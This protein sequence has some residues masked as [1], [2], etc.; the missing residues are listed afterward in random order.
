MTSFR[1]PVVGGVLPKLL[2]CMD[3]DPKTGERTG[4]TCE[5]RWKEYNGDSFNCPGG[6]NKASFLYPRKRRSNGDFHFH[7]GIDIGWEENARILSVTSGTVVVAENEYRS[8]WSHYGKLVVV[9]ARELPYYFLYAHCASICVAKGEEVKEGQLIGT[10]G[11]TFYNKKNPTQK[12]RDGPHLHFEVITK[13]SGTAPG[14]ETQLGLDMTRRGG[15]DQPRLDPLY[16]LEELGPWGMAK[17]H[18]PWGGELTRRIANARHEVIES[19]TA[20]GFFPLGANNH[21]HGGVHLPAPLGSELVAP[22]DAT[23]VAARLD[24]DAT[25]SF[26][27][28]AG[29]SNFILLRHELAEDSY[30]LFQGRD[31]TDVEPKPI[32]E[33][34]PKARA[35]GRRHCTNLPADVVAVKHALHEHLDDGG[36]P[37]YDLADLDAPETSKALWAAIAAFQA[38]RVELKS[39]DGVV[40]IPG[41][42]WTALHHGSPPTEPATEPTV[43]PSPARPLDPKRVVYSL[44]MHLQPLPLTDATANDFAWLRQVKLAPNPADPAEDQ[45]L[46]ARDDREDDLAEAKHDLKG[47]VGATSASGTHA[48]NDPG[49]VLFVCKRLVRFGYHPGP[50]A[51]TCDEPLITAIRELQN[52]HH[53]YF[54]K[55]RNGDGRVDTTGDTIGLLHK[56]RDQLLGGTSARSTSLDPIFLHR[57]TLRD[58][59]GVAKVL[60]NLDVKVRSGEPLWRSGQAAGTTPD[61][62]TSIMLEQVHWELFSEHLLVGATWEPPFEDYTEDL[63]ADVPARITTMIDDGVPELAQDGVLEPREIQAF[64]AS[65]RARFLRRTPCR[66]I[67]HWA[68]DADG[69]AARLAEIGFDPTGVAEQLR[70][71]M[72]W[73][74]AAPVLPGSHFVWHYDPVEFMAEYSEHLDA[75]RP[76]SRDPATHSAL[77]VR[78]CFDNGMPMPDAKVLLYQDVDQCSDAIRSAK[79][80]SDGIA[81]FPGVPHGDYA[82]RLE[83]PPSDMVPLA[84]VPSETT[85]ITI[86]TAV[87]GPPLPR[88]SIHVTVRKHS[89]TVAG[90]VEVWLTHATAGPV[91]G[92]VTDHGKLSFADII[93]GEYLIEAGDAE[94]V[95]VTLDKE[96][97]TLTVILPPPKGRLC[98]KV[99]MGGAAVARREV[100]ILG[101]HGVVASKLTDA[102]G[103]A[104]LELRQGHYEARVGA[105][106][107]KVYVKGNDTETYT[108]ELSE[109]QLPD[110]E[111]ALAVSVLHEDGTPA[112]TELVLVSGAD[113]FEADYPNASG[114]AGFAL[115]PGDYTIEVGDRSVRATVYASCTKWVQLEV[116]G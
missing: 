1:N 60:T 107:K 65:G 44:L 8:G 72:W 35:V 9:K 75:L 100:E 90:S 38:E 18:L 112:V 115:P 113:A 62:S 92:D 12:F 11:R 33:P 61:G 13:L 81:R 7:Q 25:G 104:V 78:V 105:A 31:P 94:P 10:V 91:L 95:A 89:F 111:G 49:D 5:N 71:F 86:A 32:S 51:P 59:H 70:P 66:F 93:Y 108:L 79:T 56:T 54:E 109:K 98:V 30:A 47:S 48:T 36:H 55:E 114:V 24:P 69:A 40:D 29:H 4:H 39:P 20:G 80:G 68:L 82:A 76:E 3:I 116:S 52:A 77:L 64:Y 22:F 83:D 23:I 73:D 84:S 15:T 26:H 96:S 58:D 97:K 57:A 87:P 85:E 17:V 2:P 67:S 27:P 63:T 110:E 43:E 99:S 37:Y 106:T 102:D 101:K 34:K 21:W 45:A 46:R 50:P 88:G 74:Q 16:I 41:K 6:C 103:V 28:G 14:K 42:T 19:S 53:P